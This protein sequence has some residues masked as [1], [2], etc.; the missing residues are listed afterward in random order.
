MNL[1]TVRVV[2][3]NWNSAWFSR[4]CLTAL[5]ATEYPTEHLEIVLVD[6]A[7]VDGSLEQIQAAF[8]YIRIIGNEANLGFAEGCNRAMRDLHGVDHVALVNNDA[9][10]DPGWLRPLVDA[11]ERDPA[12][13]AAAA[14]LVLEPAFTR[15]DIEVAVGGALLESV[16]IG[17]IDVLDRSLAFGLRSVGRPEWPMTLDHYVDDAATLLLPAGPGERSIEVT[18]RGS[19]RMTV[20]TEGDEAQLEL[21]A[22]PATTVVR[23][24]A[25]REE[26]VNGL[27]TDLNDVGEGFDRH[28][29]EP[30]ASVHGDDGVIVP[31]FCGGGV[32]LR[33]DMLREVGL[34]DPEFFAYYEDSDLAWRARSSGWH[35]VAVPES[36]IRHA[37]GGSAGSQARGFFFLNY[38][39]WLLA[40]LRSG[41]RN[42]RRRARRRV[43]QRLTWA[44]RVNV[45]SRL[46]RGRRPDGLLVWE[47]LRVV[48]GVAAAGV[49]GRRRLGRNRA[50]VLPGA[51]RTTR[52]QSRLQPPPAHRPPRSRS[53]GP[54]VVYVELPAFD[55]ESTA[56]RLAAGLTVSESRIDAVALRRSATAGSGF[57]RA[58]PAEWAGM[59]GLDPGAARGV[60]PDTLDLDELD[61]AAVLLSSSSVLS[62][63]STEVVELDELLRDIGESG[64]NTDLVGFVGRKLLEH[65][66]T[67]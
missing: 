11:L 33:A 63:G 29:G 14:L 7:S 65:F 5:T 21:A 30:L 45:L 2:V 66:H 44:I 25:D 40:V 31:G 53:G 24:G 56:A 47:W 57:R 28:Y 48:A 38:R 15:V 37:F 16:R 34:F 54:L 17:H 1:P 10:P 58:T 4:R 6:N 39:N 23:S 12:A 49:A 9:V 18:A 61:P 60:V 51:V 19:G 43:R 22:D 41:D 8:P 20:R 46:R 67:P 59:L 42:V 35:T 62:I 52:V 36:V 26:R 13:G 55:R 27:G 50:T 64:T 3:L 32:L